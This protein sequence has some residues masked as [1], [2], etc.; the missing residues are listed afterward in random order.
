MNFKRIIYNLREHLLVRAGIYNH[1]NEQG[2]K[3]DTNGEVGRVFYE[4]QEIGIL[5]P[6]LKLGIVKYVEIFSNQ[7]TKILDDWFEGKNKLE[8]ALENFNFKRRGKY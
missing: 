5:I 7:E 1:L 3:I 2:F 6:K 4:N 8:K